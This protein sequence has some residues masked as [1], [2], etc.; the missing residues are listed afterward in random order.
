M[1]VYVY[2]RTGHASSIIFKLG[3]QPVLCSSQGNQAVPLKLPAFFCAV[4][5]HGHE[6]KHINTL[7]NPKIAGKWMFMDVHDPKYSMI[8]SLVHSQIPPHTC[9][10]LPLA[11]V[12]GRCTAGWLS[13]GEGPGKYRQAPDWIGA[14]ENLQET[15]VLEV[16][17]LA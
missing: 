13:G 14:T 10:S 6:S 9:L 16:F 17:F 11:Q 4:A 2:A 1:A 3:H 15:I 12:L 7:M 8:A 5:R